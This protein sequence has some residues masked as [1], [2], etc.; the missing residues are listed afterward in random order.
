M[1]PDAS[2]HLVLFGGVFDPPHLAHRMLAQELALALAPCRLLVMPTATPPHKPP[3]LASKAHRLA[4]TRLNFADLPSL[5]ISTLE[6]ERPGTS[7]TFDTVVE[8]KRRFPAASVTVAC[9]LDAL[10]DVPGWHRA[11][12]LIELV[13]FAVFY[14]PPL[15]PETILPDLPG[16]LRRRLRFLQV[17]RFELSSTLIRDR[18]AAGLPVAAFLHPLVYNY[19]VEHALYGVV[20]SENY[21]LQAE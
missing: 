10:R 16:P 3:P 19:L 18:L 17:P 11:D 20:I 7:Y 1:K 13:D 12:E 9:G 2:L 4:M 6:L 5:E 14:R 15:S 21:S 8:L